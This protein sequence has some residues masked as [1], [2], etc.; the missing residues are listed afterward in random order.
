LKWT[1][2]PARTTGKISSAEKLAKLNEERRVTI[3]HE[4]VVQQDYDQLLPT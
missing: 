2:P 1:T 3:Q 4:A